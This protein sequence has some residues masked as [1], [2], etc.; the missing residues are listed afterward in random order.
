V[1]GSHHQKIVI[2]D[3]A[4]AFCGGMDLTNRRWDTCDHLANDPRRVWNESPYPPFHDLMSVVDGEVV[5]GLV[6]IARDRWHRATGEALPACG[7]HGDP[8]PA[9][10]TPQMTNVMVGVSRTH[11]ESLH[12]AEV[13]ENEALY[14]DMIGRAQRYIYIENQYFTAD[15]LANA[16]AARLAERDGP[17]VVMVL[18][19][20][21]HGWL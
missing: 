4:V 17:E 7:T 1:G 6:E 3:D 8:W 21:S 13:R 9:S 14:L 20:L 10:V 5:A 19:L 2:I 12:S 15:K 16:L 11:P 18:R